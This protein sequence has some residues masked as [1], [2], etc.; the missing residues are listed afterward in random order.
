MACSGL[1]GIRGKLLTIFAS[2]ECRLR[3]RLRF[4]G[5]PLSLTIPDPDSSLD[6]TRFITLGQS[7]VR[8][9][10]AVVHTD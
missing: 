6:E 2:I 3:K 8:R 5:D 1:N 10:L 9:L 7:N 4:F